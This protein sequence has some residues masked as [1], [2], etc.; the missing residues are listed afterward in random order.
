MRAKVCL[1][2][3]CQRPLVR[4]CLRIVGL[5]V[6][7]GLLRQCFRPR[8]AP[9]QLLKLRSHV[10]QREPHLI[11]SLLYWLALFLTKWGQEIE[12]E[13]TWRLGSA[14]LSRRAKEKIPG[15]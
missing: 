14:T 8:V 13:V 10:S 11:W 12:V 9:H 1:K 5:L 3:I 2:P 15:A 7:C 4:I 6:A